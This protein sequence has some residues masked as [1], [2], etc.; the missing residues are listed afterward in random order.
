MIEPAIKMLRTINWEHGSAIV[1]FYQ[2]EVVRGEDQRLMGGFTHVALSNGW[3]EVLPAP[4]L[5]RAHAGARKRA[6]REAL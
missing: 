1:T 4:T 6:T 5:T 3:A 2:G